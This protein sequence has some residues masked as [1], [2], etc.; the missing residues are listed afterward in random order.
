MLT[1]DHI[2]KHYRTKDIADTIIRVSTD[3]EYS[4]AGMKCTPEAYI[5]HETGELKDSMDWYKGT[6]SYK[7]RKFLKKIDLSTGTEGI[8]VNIQRTLYWTLNLFDKE[9][10]GV[11]FKRVNQVE[12]PFISRSYSCGYTLG[13]DIDK[14]HGKDP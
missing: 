1:I 8:P 11:D 4:R 12:K 7:D 9:I 10:Y 6:G 13:V 2:R 3:G 14:E 5:D